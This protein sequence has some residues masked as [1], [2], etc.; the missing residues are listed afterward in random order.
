MSATDRPKRFELKDPTVLLYSKEEEE[1]DA[2][3]IERRLRRPQVFRA[4]P[5]GYS[6]DRRIAVVHMSFPWSGGFHS[7][8]ATWVLRR[9][10][11]GWSVLL[12]QFVYYV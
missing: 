6:P 11:D 12:R 4:Y 10:P 5:P 2:R 9:G 3:D 7:G 8:V 1:K